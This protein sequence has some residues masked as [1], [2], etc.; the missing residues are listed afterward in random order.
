M[1]LVS[2]HRAHSG[3]CSDSVPGCIDHEGIHLPVGWQ[4]QRRVATGVGSTNGQLLALDIEI[5][6]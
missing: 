4:L 2:L 5:D 6:I 1:P 3:W